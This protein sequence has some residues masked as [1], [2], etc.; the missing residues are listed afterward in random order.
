MAKQQKRWTADHAGRALDQA[1][2]AASDQSFADRIGINAQ[3]LSWWRRQLDRPRRGPRL[4][5]ERTESVAFVEVAQG[6]SAAIGRASS[7]TVV[8]V[9]LTNGRQL[10][11]S[12]LIDA[13][14][15]TRLANAL[16]GRCLA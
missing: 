9:L 7:G 5:C 6:A 3:R 14:R 4:G 8:E 13:E 1:D 16:E 10:R 12:E 2:R 11:V 15:L